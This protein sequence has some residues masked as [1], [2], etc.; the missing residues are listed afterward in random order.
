[1]KPEDQQPVRRLIMPDPL[2]GMVFVGLV[3]RVYPVA[4][5]DE[6]P[7]APRRPTSARTPIQEDGESLLKEVLRLRSEGYRHRRF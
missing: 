2:A 3:G 5:I 1:M 4:E 7:V 6:Q